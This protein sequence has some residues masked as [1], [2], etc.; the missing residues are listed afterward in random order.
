MDTAMIARN[1]RRHYA[2]KGGVPVWNPSLAAFYV[3][4]PLGFRMLAFFPAKGF[5]W[6]RVAKAGKRKAPA[7]CQ[8]I[9]QAPAP[10]INPELSA[11]LEGAA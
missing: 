1:A 2:M 9:P 11:Y 8:E 4:I 7:Q 3:L 6:A 10:T 5:D